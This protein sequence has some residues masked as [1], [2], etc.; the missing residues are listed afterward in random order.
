MS[1]DVIENLYHWQPSC[2]SSRKEEAVGK[3]HFLS[4]KVSLGSVSCMSDSQTSVGAGLTNTVRRAVTV[5]RHH[6]LVHRPSA[7]VNPT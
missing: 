1:K 3:M 7:E 2:L 4:S 5:M 6:C